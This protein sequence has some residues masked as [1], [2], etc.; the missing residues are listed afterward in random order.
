MKKGTIFM[1]A[2]L[3]FASLMTILATIFFFKNHELKNDLHYAVQSYSTAVEKSK[4]Q[5]ER[6]QNKEK[7]QL[8]S[9]GNFLKDSIEIYTISKKELFLKE[10]IGKDQIL[11]LRYSEYDC[12]SCYEGFWSVFKEFQNEY[13]EIQIILLA[14]YN[15]LRDLN[16]FIDRIGFKGQVYLL[17]EKLDLPIENFKAPF[18]FLL[19]NGAQCQNIYALD[20]SNLLQ[21]GEILSNLA[22]SKT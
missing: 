4:Y 6:Y 5:T 2:L 12:Y 13:P 10:L 19:N 7:L 18:F 3:I 15:N 11:I 16:L 1:I 22:K 20:K 8:L 14:K 9:E 21:C 17:K